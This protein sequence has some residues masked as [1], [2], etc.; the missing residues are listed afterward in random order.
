M[1]EELRILKKFE[2]EFDRIL[3]LHDSLRTSC[4]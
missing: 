2:E 1:D 3:T 4:C